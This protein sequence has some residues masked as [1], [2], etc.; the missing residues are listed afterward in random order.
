MITRC[1]L[2]KVILSTKF[3]LNIILAGIKGMINFYINQ[4]YKKGELT[5]IKLIKEAENSHS[6]Q[7]HSV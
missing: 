1:C 2:I 4:S 7:R 6:F 5:K 3:I